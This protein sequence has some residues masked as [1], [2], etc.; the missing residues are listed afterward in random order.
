[1]PQVRIFIADQHPVVRQGLISIINKEKDMTVIAETENPKDIFSIIKSMNP[2]MGIINIS[3]GGDFGPELI[4]NIKAIFPKL[5]V[6]AISTHNEGLLAERIIKAGAKGYIMKNENPENLMAAIRKVSK[7]QIY[8]SDKVTAKFMDR[9]T[10]RDDGSPIENLTDRELEIYILIGEGHGVKQIA[11][12][13]YLSTKTIETYK[14][15]LKEKLNIS[16]ASEL[17]RHAVLWL[18][19]NTK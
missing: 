1:M 7:Q 12:K 4:K 3:I 8:T 16:N 13:L 9:I 11:E 18:N 19:S 15:K 14:A 5:P 6:L 2:D 17:R 10:H